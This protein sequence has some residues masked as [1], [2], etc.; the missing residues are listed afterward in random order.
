MSASP[1]PP[2]LVPE[3]IAAFGEA[4]RQAVYDVIALRRD[5]R[6]FEAGRP[7][8]DAILRRI[9]AAAHLAPSVGLSQPWGFILVRDEAQRRRI[10]ESFLLCRQ[11][12]PPA[13]PRDAASST[14][15]TGSKGS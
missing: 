10:R 1:D 3:A 13:I 11:A 4:A 14:S 15:P 5:V 6:H 8:E 9:L 2:Y 7:V 12:G